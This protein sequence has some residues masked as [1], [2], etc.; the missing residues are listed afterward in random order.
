MYSIINLSFNKFIR[1]L[2]IEIHPNITFLLIMNKKTKFDLINTANQNHSRFLTA[3]KNTTVAF[4]C[5]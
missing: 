3:E 1:F 5:Y 2:V 4:F